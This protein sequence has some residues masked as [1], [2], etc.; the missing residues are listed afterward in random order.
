[1]FGFDKVCRVFGPSPH[2]M[3]VM[4]LLL[5]LAKVRIIPVHLLAFRASFASFTSCAEDLAVIA[6]PAPSLDLSQNTHTLAFF[7]AAALLNHSC[8]PSCSLFYERGFGG[9]LTAQVVR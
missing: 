8:G 7:P 5:L 2:L 3:R 1:M 4:M 9:Q 6:T